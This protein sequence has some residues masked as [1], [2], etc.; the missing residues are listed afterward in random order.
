M[1]K[2]TEYI[3]ESDNYDGY[4]ST[5]V[6]VNNEEKII[7]LERYFLIIFQYKW[8]LI[9][10]VFVVLLLSAFYASRLPKGYNSSFN[11]YYEDVTKANYEYG[12]VVQSNLDIQYWE[13][14]MKS[15]R[16]IS[17]VKETSG[18]S[19]S[20]NRMKRFFS[21]VQKKNTDNILL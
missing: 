17:L 6:G 5:K 20:S 4:R 3:E 14:I 2:S 9:I 12:T 16:L 7:D 15:D 19:Y 11:I 10:S 18:F 1:K 21:I 13:E 8:V